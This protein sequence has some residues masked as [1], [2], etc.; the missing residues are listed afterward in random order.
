MSIELIALDP[1]PTQSGYVR[2]RGGHCFEGGMLPNT[3]VLDLLL[4]NRR[5][6]ISPTVVVEFVQNM[7]M[8]A[9]KELFE[10][11]FWVGRFCQACSPG[12]FERVYRMDIKHHLC[13]TAKAKQPHI[14]QALLDRFGGKDQA[15]GRKKAPGPLYGIKG[16]AWSALAV[17]VY[18]LETHGMT[19]KAPNGPQDASE[20]IVGWIDIM[21]GGGH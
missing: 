14:R 2:W 7:G 10:T 18:W 16:H 5:Q 1:G 11:C 17:A 21:D 13:G 19:S 9:G 12:P 20:G 6:V 3:E 4:E 15:I 8:P